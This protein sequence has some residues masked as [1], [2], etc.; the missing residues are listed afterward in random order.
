MELR[1]VLQHT[2]NYDTSKAEAGGL[3]WTWGHTGPHSELKVTLDY[4][5]E[6]CLST[7]K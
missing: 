1:I 7:L 3:Q 5:I 2:Y 6:P 4:I